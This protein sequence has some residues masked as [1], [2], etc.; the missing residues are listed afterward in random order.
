MFDIGGNR[1]RLVVRFDYA[2]RMEFVRFVGMHAEYD[3]IDASSVQ[4]AAMDIQPIES[5]ADYGEALSAIDGLMGA[6]PG[7]P[8]SDTLKVLIVLVNSYEARRWPVDPPDPVSP[9]EHVMEARGYGR[10]DLAALLGSGPRASDVLVR[11]YELAGG[12]PGFP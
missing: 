4:E 2:Y 12:R 9:I 6:A 10:K 5:E 11:D 8:E 7:G 1:H 3:S